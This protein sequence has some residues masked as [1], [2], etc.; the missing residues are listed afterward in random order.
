[1][2]ARFKFWLISK[3]NCCGHHCT[4]FHPLLQ[5]YLCCRLQLDSFHFTLPAKGVAVHLGSGGILQRRQDSALTRAG[6]ATALP[7]EDLLGC[8]AE[9]TVGGWA[10]RTRH[11]MPGGGHVLDISSGSPK[12]GETAPWKMPNSTFKS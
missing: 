8:M 6:I 11:L 7:R 12:R 2:A 3:G 4:D 5:G 9:L 10:E 1:M